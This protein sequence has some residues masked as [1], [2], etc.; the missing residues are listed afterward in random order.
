MRA[1]AV[2][3]VISHIAR[4]RPPPTICS[5]RSRISAAA[6]LV[7]VIARICSG[8]RVAA[9]HQV[10][11]AVCQHARLAGTGPGEHQ[12]RAA[13]MHDRRLLGLVQARKQV[14]VGEELGHRSSIAPRAERPFERFRCA[15]IP[16]PR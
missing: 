5:T 8:L 15:K 4:A 6:L 13:A 12:Q 16:A 2:W 10:G 14:G 3:K 1:Q 9:L 7:K 11:D